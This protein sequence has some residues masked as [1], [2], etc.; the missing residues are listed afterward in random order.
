MKFTF[1]LK[2]HLNKNEQQREGS[3][4]KIWSPEKKKKNERKTKQES[5]PNTSLYK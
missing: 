2:K 4:S 3:F 5:T 1:T